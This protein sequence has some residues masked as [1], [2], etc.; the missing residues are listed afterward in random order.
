MGEKGIIF[1]ILYI[2]KTD[3]VLLYIIIIPTSPVAFK[4]LE[5]L[6]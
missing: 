3:G 5:M 2:Y 6:I 1:I 4:E